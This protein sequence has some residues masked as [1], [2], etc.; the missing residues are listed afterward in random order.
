[1][2]AEGARARRPHIGAPQ[3]AHRQPYK[4][5][6]RPTALNRLAARLMGLGPVDHLYSVIH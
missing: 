2:R 1:M 6:L 5:A 3:V 4:E